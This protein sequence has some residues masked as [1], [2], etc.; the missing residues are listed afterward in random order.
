MKT[1]IRKV[2]KLS[3]QPVILIMREDTM[4]IKP[5]RTTKHPKYSKRTR[6][7]IELFH[8]LNYLYSKNILENTCARKKVT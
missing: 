2:V 6:T 4:A 1:K 5:T 3:K 8:M 7:C